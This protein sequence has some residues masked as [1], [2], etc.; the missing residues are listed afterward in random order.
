MRDITSGKYSLLIGIWN[1]HEELNY[2]N[3]MLLNPNS[4]IGDNLL[5]SLNYLCKKSLSI[6]DDFKIIDMIGLNEKID[7]YLF[8]EYP[9]MGNKYG[10]KVKLSMKFLSTL[11]CLI[12]IVV[13]L[14]LIGI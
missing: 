10:K 9:R 11:T 13:M 5:L 7:V 1:F 2:N 3:Y 8:L 4:L 12:S 6:G 14:I